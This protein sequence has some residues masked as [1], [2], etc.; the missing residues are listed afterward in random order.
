LQAPI[1]P[2]APDP[3]FAARLRRRL[4]RLTHQQ[5]EEHEMA[6]VLLRGGLSRNG[7]HHGDVSYLTL[8]LPDAARGRR[9]YG[10]VLGWTFGT[11]Q[12]ETDG[13]Q[14]DEVI[15]QVGLWPSSAWREGV[16]AGAIPGFRVDDIAVAV[17]A[18]R[19]HGGTA[20]GPQLRP[21]GL[22]AEG[23]DGQSL[24]FFLHE[25]PPSGE[26]AGPNGER[27]GDVSYLVLRVADVPR[28]QRLFS[29]VLGWRFAPG[30]TGLHVEGA[31]PMAGVSEGPPGA[32]LCYQV[33][34]IAVAVE[35]VRAAGG[36]AGEV[37]TRPYGLESLCA[38][39]QGV[40][41]YLHQFG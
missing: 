10:S 21:Y 26:P 3:G 31:V 23:T 17:E 24:R 28:A 22:E 30:G 1:V 41:F 20:S 29:V 18:V 13:N 39:D 40:E 12:L 34:D 32:T 2:V 15:P 8:A 38:D 14:V 37:Q 16:A 5:E 33:D 7:T 9:F 11:G 27:H 6:D 35:A 25:L 36:R 19:A 4:E